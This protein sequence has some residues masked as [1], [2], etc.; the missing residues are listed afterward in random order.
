VDEQDLERTPGDDSDMGQDRQQFSV[1][2]II[3]V[4]ASGCGKTTVGWI[5][6]RLLGYGFI[7]L[8]SMIEK[9]EKKSVEQIFAE[10]GESKFRALERVALEELEEIRSHVISVG[11]GA[12]ADDECWDLMRRI[13]TTVWLNT[14]AQEIARRLLLDPKE[15]DKRPLLKEVSDEGGAKAHRD[16][17]A[18]RIAALIGFRIRRYKEADLVMNDSFSNQESTAKSLKALLVKAGAISSDSENNPHDRW[19]IL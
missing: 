14:S 16:L 12:V 3:L 11:G 17:L 7:D 6:S 10:Q 19:Q 4:G 15:L 8:D 13:G 9:S 5:L 2:N 18:E 1:G